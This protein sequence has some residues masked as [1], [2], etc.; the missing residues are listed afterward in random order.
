MSKKP[1]D[2]QLY[3]TAAKHNSLTAAA[4]KYN[5]TRYKVTN[6]IKKYC[7]ETGKPH[8]VQPTQYPE[9]KEIY[10]K[11]LELGSIRKACYY[12][13]LD[14]EALTRRLWKYCRQNDLD[15]P[16]GESRNEPKSTVSITFPSEQKLETG[17]IRRFIV[18]SAHNNTPI[19]GKAFEALRRAAEHMGAQLCVIPLLYKNPSLFTSAQALAVDWPEEIKRYT[20]YDNIIINDDWM[21]AGKLHV[22]ATAARPLQGMQGFSKERSCVIGHA[23]LAWETRPTPP[24]RPAIRQITTGSVSVPQ[25][26]DSKLGQLS[27]FHHTLGALLIET[28]G[29]RTFVR[30]L[31]PSVS[32]GEFFDFE[33]WYGPNGYYG[34]DSVAIKAFVF[35][36]LHEWFSTEK[37]LIRAMAARYKPLHTF[38]HDPIDGFSI[39]PHHENDPLMRIAKLTLGMGKLDDEVQSLVDWHKEL[40][41]AN[42]DGKIV[43]VASNHTD[44]IIKWMKS[45]EWSKID[46]NSKAHRYLLNAYME[47]LED[48]TNATKYAE[49]GELPSI[50]KVLMQRA[51][52]K[53]IIPNYLAN[54]LFPSDNESVMV[55]DIECGQHG[56]RGPN[57]T[58]GTPGAFRQSQYKMI[59]GHIHSPG[60]YDGIYVVGTSSNLQLNYNH[61]LSGWD[62]VHASV[63]RLD[64]R[65]LFNTVGGKY[66]LEE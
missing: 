57:G 64:K 26:S 53:Q 62:S 24:G 66:R 49:L 18:T 52:W 13:K 51:L 9:G 11:V 46:P 15:I 20:V 12:L 59:I 19:N 17:G 28:D 47:Y 50:L 14:R 21:I 32:T 35:G 34:T 8:P 16:E 31:R 58:K 65:R 42:P 37:Y 27:D 63:D 61:G 56:H 43:Y 55:G 22:Q 2:K 30:H 4:D 40:C 38:V 54:T 33:H 60:I 1:T 45:R 41:A 5:I 6:R 25:Y 48:K 23:R 36:D 39:S 10:D 29:V 44:H 3:D 7:E